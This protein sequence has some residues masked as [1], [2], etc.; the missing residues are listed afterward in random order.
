MRPGTGTPNLRTPRRHPGQTEIRTEPQRDRGGGKR[1]A[2]ERAGQ[3]G[4]RIDEPDR[5]R[6]G[7]QSGLRLERL[8]RNLRIETAQLRLLRDGLALWTAPL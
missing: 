6:V 3:V 7:E 8:R 1:R 4:H 5:V 2:R